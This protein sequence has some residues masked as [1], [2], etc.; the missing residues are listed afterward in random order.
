MYKRQGYQFFFQKGIVS[1]TEKITVDLKNATLNEVL[2][3]VLKDH[4]YSYEV[5]DGVIIVR[6]MVEQMCIRDR[7]YP[8][9]RKFTVGL[10]I[11]F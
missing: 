10:S 6:R 7:S 4:G 11:N 3:K 5:L 9:P 1:E 2:D 8:L